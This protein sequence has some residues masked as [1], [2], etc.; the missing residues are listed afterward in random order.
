M[1]NMKL[2]GV[3]TQGSRDIVD[4]PLPQYKILSPSSNI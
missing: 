3:S 4:G 2:D 1:E